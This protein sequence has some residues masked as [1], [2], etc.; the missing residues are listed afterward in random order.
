MALK[1][2]DTPLATT[3]YPK[4]IEPTIKKT[5]STDPDTGVTTYK[6][7]WSNSYGKRT[8]APTTKTTTPLVKRTTAPVARTSSKPVARTT[9]P[10]ARTS[11]SSGTTSGSRE[12]TSLPKLTPAGRTDDTKPSAPLA[13]I[14]EKATPLTKQE[15]KEI[16]YKKSYESSKKTGESFNDWYAKLDERTKA[17]SAK[18]RS[19]DSE[20][21]I[22][23]DKQMAGGCRGCR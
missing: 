22:R 9:A 2:K 23:T 4:E 1:R 8:S 13:K 14:K 15:E 18:N 20:G 21:E 5:Q 11:S 3:S 10:A 12:F 7:S 19:K 17:N 16:I 6:H